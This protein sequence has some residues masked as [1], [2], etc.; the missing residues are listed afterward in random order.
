MVHGPGGRNCSRATEAS[1]SVRPSA[2]YV[3]DRS[4]CARPGCLAARAGNRRNNFN[5][6]WRWTTEPDESAAGPHDH[7][8]VGRVLLLASQFKVA[9]R[10]RS[11]RTRL[12]VLFE[13]NS[14]PL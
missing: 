8:A 2:R 4:R 12:E 5:S 7:V 13:A 10:E 6:L 14:C 1:A 3:N 11:A 9:F